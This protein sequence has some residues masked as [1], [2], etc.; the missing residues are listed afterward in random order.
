DW[1]PQ[2][3][4]R[5]VYNDDYIRVDGEY[6]GSRPRRDADR[7]AARLAGFEH[8]RLLDYGSGAGLFTGRLRELG[9]A[10]VEDY[11]PFSNPNRP[12][13][14]FDVITCFEVLEHTPNPIATL[15]D[16]ASFLDP[17]G[18]V[19]CGTSLQQPD[20]LTVRAN[21]WYVAP[22]NGH[23]SIYSLHTLAT[24]AST[25]GLT[26]YEGPE[27]ALATASPSP[28]SAHLLAAGGRPVRMFKLTAPGRGAE[29]PA[30]Q[31]TCWNPVE[32]KEFGVFRWTKEPAIA[33]R[34]QADALAP[35][36][37]IL[38]I[39]VHAEVRSGFAQECWLEL[40]TQMVPLL[41]QAD[42]LTARLTLDEE[43]EAVVRLITPP[44]LRPCDLRPVKDARP[45][46]IQV[47]CA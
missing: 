38:S 25:L 1:S 17:G 39:P 32:E 5:F 19:L 7:I 22:R 11:D 12:A 40:G 13:G 10:D 8:L 2:D 31:A 45:L 37:V 35:C 15:R 28:A 46:G 18:I 9:F 4:A 21:W 29:V 14:T 41:R 47:M 43:T 30:W 23:A 44:P 33:W 16:M 3:F 36:R 26:L 6:A 27:L 42:T 24:A 20:F 34:L